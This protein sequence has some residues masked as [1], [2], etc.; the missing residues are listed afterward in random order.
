[1]IKKL[2]WNITDF[3]NYLVNKWYNYYNVIKL[4]I[5][6]RVEEYM[7]EL[8]YYYDLGDLKKRELTNFD[9]FLSNLD[10]FR[11]VQKTKDTIKI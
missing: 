4:E 10:E 9:E 3:F 8:K 11:I 2:V 7:Q 6:M 1:M 5:I